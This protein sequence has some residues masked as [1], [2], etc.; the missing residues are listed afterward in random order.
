MS[1]PVTPGLS[2]TSSTVVTGPT[3]TP[4]LLDHPFIDDLDRLVIP[5]VGPRPLV[6]WTRVPDCRVLRP[7][8][9]GGR[10]PRV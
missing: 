2:V 3:P 6:L 8:T 10:P 9:R 7:A 5:S 4:G 1:A